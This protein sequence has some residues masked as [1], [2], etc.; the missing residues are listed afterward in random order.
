MARVL[1][2]LR[3]DEVSAVDRAAGEGT[4]I[5]LMKRHDAPTE[6]ASRRA[7]FL[8]IF[9]KAD[10]AD[11][12][13]NDAGG[14]GDDAGGLANHPVVSLARLLIASGHKADI[15]SALD[16]L[17]NTPHG[18]ALLHRT[19]THKGKDFPPMKDSLTAIMKDLGPVSL[20]KAIVDRGRAPCDEASLVA[21]L[22]E[23][24]A[25]QFNL[26][27]D[28]AFAKLY[29]AEESVRR[30]CAIAKAAEFSVFDVQPIEVGFEDAYTE[31]ELTAAAA[32]SAEI[33]RLGR[34][35]FPF[36][37]ADQQFA[38]VFEDKNYRALAEQVHRRPSPTT[39]YAMPRSAYAKA[40]PAPNADSAYAE[41]MVKAAELRKTQP[42]LTEAQAF[43]QVFT[44]PA[45][46]ELA[47][48]ERIES[49]P[50]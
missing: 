26:P 48:R 22:S 18:A 3:I 15:A 40:D 27:G 33:T 11:D 42:T 20:C 37:S 39:V 35:K 43:A 17:L 14:G 38:R 8:K 4:R 23:H 25:K 32:A 36:L 47:K 2:K 19:S 24:A 13:G 1:T 30:A 34:E 16:Y 44:A 31:R 5:I 45:N 7:Y 10:A 28:R 29:E 6:A 21:A 41:L 9:T 12:G 46:I 50:R 49:A